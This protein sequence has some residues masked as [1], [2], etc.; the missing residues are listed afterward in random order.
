MN[1]MSAVKARS[2]SPADRQDRT[3][4]GQISVLLQATFTMLS[5]LPG[6]FVDELYLCLLFPD[7]LRY[8]DV[9]ERS[10]VVR[11]AFNRSAIQNVPL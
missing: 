4:E 3:V 9:S 10:D 2:Q 5:L 6:N 8:S 11:E 7:M 1:K